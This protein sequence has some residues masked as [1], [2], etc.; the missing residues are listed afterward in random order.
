MTTR[1]DLPG[2]LSHM[3]SQQGVK[4][5]NWRDLPV[6]IV[7]TGPSAA[8][9]NY[10]L[11]KGLAHVFV[12]KSSMRLAPWADAV[13]G[14]DVGWWIASQGAK[15]FE[16]IKFSPSPTVCKVFPEIQQIYLRNTKRLVPEPVGTVAVGDSGFQAINLAVQFGAR[17]IVLCGFDMT[18]NIHGAHWHRDYNGISRPDPK[19]ME[20]WRIRLDASANDFLN[21]GVDVVNASMISALK[22]YRIEPLADAVM[23]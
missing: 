4:W 16:G 14:I 10:L 7:G 15:E 2:R 6:V 21:L 20:E 13:Y 9:Q 18:M 8:V 19:R 5:P 23:E 17:K 22:N 3:N 11:I 1:E 12:I